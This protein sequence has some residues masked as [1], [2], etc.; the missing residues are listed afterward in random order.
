MNIL[1]NHNKEVEEKLLKQ[2]PNL[3]DSTEEGGYDA[4][5]YVLSFIT[6]QNKELLKKIAEGEIEKNK[7]KIPIQTALWSKVYQSLIKDGVKFPKN[8][9]GIGASYGGLTAICE[10]LQEYQTDWQQVLQELE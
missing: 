10:V 1:Q 2:F 4:K 3:N 6:S 5:P 9:N 8:F 7:N